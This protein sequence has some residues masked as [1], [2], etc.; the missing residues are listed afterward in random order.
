MF[1][2]ILRGGLVYDGLGNSPVKMD[3][4]VA[5]GAIRA[6]GNLAES[7]GQ[8]IELRRVCRVAGIHRYPYALG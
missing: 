8:M 4:G 5:G 7:A 2:F 6:T 1:D 3:I